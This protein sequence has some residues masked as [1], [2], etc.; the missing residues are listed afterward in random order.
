MILKSDLSKIMLQEL[1]SNIKDKDAFKRFINASEA[2][3]LILE[4]VL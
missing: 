3:D 1:Y 4:E 2:S